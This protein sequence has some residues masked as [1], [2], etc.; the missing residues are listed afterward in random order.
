MR[1]LYRFFVPD[2]IKKSV[3]WPATTTSRPRWNA[4]RFSG[5]PRRR[6]LDP[7]KRF[8][9]PGRLDGKRTGCGCSLP[10]G[11]QYAGQRRNSHSGV[12]Q[13]HDAR[14][15]PLPF[16]A[17]PFPSQRR[18]D[19]RPVQPPLCLSLSRDALDQYARPHVGNSRWKNHFKAA[20]HT[21]R[22]LVSSGL[23]K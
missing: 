22:P 4:S 7:Q 2:A 13:C 16:R 18:R 15:T 14:S 11:R 20:Q 1:S 23:K 3:T 19:C 9:L 17:E 5:R 6:T 21:G 10:A 12:N 8:H